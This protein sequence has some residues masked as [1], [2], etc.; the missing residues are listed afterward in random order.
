MEDDLMVKFN[1]LFHIQTLIVWNSWIYILL[2]PNDIQT[3]KWLG[4][5]VHHIESGCDWLVLTYELIYETVWHVTLSYPLF[6]FESDVTGSLLT[7]KS[8]YLEQEESYVRLWLNY[9]F[10]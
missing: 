3:F 9:I 1:L 7:F 8:D 2:A 6:L 5:G 10:T 4:Y